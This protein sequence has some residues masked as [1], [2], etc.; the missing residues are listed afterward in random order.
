[1]AHIPSPAGDDDLAE[2]R[3]LLERIDQ[4]LALVEERLVRMWGEWERLAP[5][6]EAATSSAPMRY[7]LALR[8]HRGGKE[9]G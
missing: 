1:M 3:I 7:A 2:V 9:R 6:A 8:G 5:L 4:R